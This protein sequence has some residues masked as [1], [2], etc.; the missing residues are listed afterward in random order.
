MSRGTLRRVAGLS[1]RTG[2]G[3]GFDVGTN[4]S[5]CNRKFNMAHHAIDASTRKHGLMQ[6]VGITRVQFTVV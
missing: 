6:L 2:I 1:R 3:M 4:P 5:S